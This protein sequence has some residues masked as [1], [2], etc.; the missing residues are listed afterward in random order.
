MKRIRESSCTRNVKKIK[1]SE[2]GG[3]CTSKSRRTL[4]KKKCG[5][6][7]MVTEERSE[8]VCDDSDGGRFT[9]EREE[10]NRA[11]V[12]MVVTGERVE[13]E[14]VDSCLAGVAREGGDGEGADTGMEVTE[15]RGC[16]D[17]KGLSSYP[18]SL[19]KKQV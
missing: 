1:S 4:R 13:R 6:S 14:D 15:E 7:N 19:K 8:R 10:R 17:Y 3:D 9:R 11:N 18:L 12:G 16:G 5:T 2:R